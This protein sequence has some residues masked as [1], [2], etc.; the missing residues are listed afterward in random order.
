MEVEVAF[1]TSAGQVG[2]SQASNKKARLIP[3]S[4]RLVWMQMPIAKA[5]SSQAV[6]PLAVH[7]HPVKVMDGKVFLIFQCCPHRA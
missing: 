5:L 4:K 7:Y 3:S 6:W 2:V 1:W